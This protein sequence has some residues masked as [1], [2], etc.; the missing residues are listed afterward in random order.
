MKI[1]VEVPDGEY[2]DKCI[3]IQVPCAMEISCLLLG[4]KYLSRN[5]HTEIINGQKHWIE[6][7][8]K[9]KDCPSLKS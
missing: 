6:H 8:I 7:I 4:H 2:C 3:F 5:P 1:E 9:D